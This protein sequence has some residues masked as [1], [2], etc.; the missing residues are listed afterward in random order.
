MQVFL[1]THDRVH[2][3]AENLVAC[4]PLVVGN[5]IPLMRCPLESLRSLPSHKS[6]LV[7]LEHEES[8]W[9]PMFFTSSIT[10]NDHTSN[11]TL[12]WDE[13]HL[14]PYSWRYL[15]SGVIPPM[16]TSVHSR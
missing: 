14:M 2:G 5:F 8:H 1:D 3:A 11:I 4:L 7:Y 6:H 15:I 10:G 16:L 13:C 9:E 12:H